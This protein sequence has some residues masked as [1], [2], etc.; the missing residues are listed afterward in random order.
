MMGRGGELEVAGEAAAGKG[1]G[2]RGEWVGL[3]NMQNNEPER[4]GLG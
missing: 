2:I 1:S 4:D 3:K